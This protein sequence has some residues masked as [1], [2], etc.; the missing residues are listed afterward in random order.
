VA[1]AGIEAPIHI[2]T[3]P[4]AQAEPTAQAARLT[5]QDNQACQVLQDLPLAEHITATALAHLVLVVETIIQ[6]VAALVPLPTDPVPLTSMLEQVPAEPVS[7]QL[8][9]VVLPMAVVVV[10]LVIIQVMVA[11]TVAAAAALVVLVKT[12]QVVQAADQQEIQVATV[13]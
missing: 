2:L 8:S 11:A 9:V 1:L 7:R 12:A 10:A 4:I 5:E 3:M 13:M 6:V